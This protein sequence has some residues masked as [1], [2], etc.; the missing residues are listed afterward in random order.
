MR[1]A[2]IMAGGFGTRLRPL[3][4]SLPKPM[5]PVANKPMMAHIVD[6]LVRHG[7]TDVVSVL[8]FQPESIRNYFGDGAQRNISMRYIMA[9]TDYGTAGA[10][11]NA[12]SLLDE[13]FIVISGDVLTDFDLTAA[14]SYHKACGAMATILLTRV[15]EPLQY[16]I[17]MTRE[18]GRISRFLEKPSWGQVFSD[19]INTGIYILEPEVLSL[20]P[21]KTE[22]DFSKDL[23]PLMLERNLPLYGYVAS[24][25]WKDIGNL[26]EYQL[27]HAD[28]LTGKVS[29]SIPGEACDSCHCGPNLNIA[30][31]VNLN[32]MV[33]L[34]DNVTIGEG[35]SL[36]DC[37]VSDDV[38]IGRGVRMTN[39][40]VWRGT[41]IGDGTDITNSVIC[42]D[43]RIG[44]YTSVLD[45]VF[46]AEECTIGDNASLLANIKLW[47]RKVVES[48]AILARSLVQEERWARELFTDARISGISNVDINP[49]FG[50]KL[51]AA[52]GNAFK[53]ATI[54]LASR[55]DDPVSRMM[56]R[57]VTAG[58]MSVGMSVDDMQVTS[59]PQ[60]RHQMQ[61]GNYG[62]GFHVRRSP[63]YP[64]KTD[65]VL[66]DQSGRDISLAI[67]K[68]IDRFFFGEDIKRVPSGDVGR[69][70]FPERTVEKYVS[71]V[72]EHVD[73]DAISR[74]NFRLLVDYS[75]G[76]S[77]L[78]FPRVLGRLGCDV[79]ALNTYVDVN[80]SSDPM[81]GSLDKAATI[82]QSLGYHVGVRIDYGG[83]RV[84]L[85][86]ERGIWYQGLRLLT[87]VTKLF[88]DAHRSLEPYTIAVPVQAPAEIET[89]AADHK[90]KVARI[91]NSHA[92]M[93]EATR[94]PDVKFVGG[95]RGGFIF[96]DFL[97]AVDGMYAACKILE[98]IARTGYLL[99]ELDQ[100]LPK[101][102][103]TIIEVQCDWE[104]RGQVMRKAMQ[105]SEG[106]NRLLVDGVKIFQGNQSVLIVPDKERALFIIAA[107]ADS[108]VES[109]LLATTYA[110][111]VKQWR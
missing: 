54:V 51:G 95:T 74:R 19:T 3:T 62:A 83:E 12:S 17:V 75:Y 49:E 4:M 96:P 31:N 97:I 22:F 76:T 108:E 61:A 35:S 1:K 5:V 57:A 73:K 28:I 15:A 34:G 64:E 29:I 20:I 48:G 94:D 106:M 25:Y 102:H 13:Q 105:H 37:V 53:S 87:L 46:I 21:E 82:M 56:K 104:Q 59:I 40:V 30:S 47:P 90:V 100:T 38:I 103:Q 107:E 66:F 58:L 14:I 7:I 32:G 41:T 36:T 98:M 24:G 68:S 85:L 2:V 55:D 52:M 60:T 84:T 88:L 50:A 10:V 45:N 16:G 8:Y 63:R 6:L 72:L 33:A 93:M 79:V 27:A 65:I 91:R 71:R 99:S 110:N 81:R 26:N 80:R 70:R 23:F 109:G 42:N 67:T 39:S 9:D 77:S 18:D 69:L 89:I 86:D 43:V 92:A 111:F 78:V 101:R 44:N 11:R